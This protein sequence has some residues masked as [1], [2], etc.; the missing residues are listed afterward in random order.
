VNKPDRG[1][2]RLLA[3]AYENGMH[4]NS[5]ASRIEGVIKPEEDQAQP[6]PVYKL[7]SH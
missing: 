5:A 1:R 4:E 2:L 6:S 3:G 7:T